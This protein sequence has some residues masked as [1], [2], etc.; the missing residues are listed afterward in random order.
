MKLMR[1]CDEL[2]IENYRNLGFWNMKYRDYMYYY[3][4]F[5]MYFKLIFRIW[6]VKL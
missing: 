4:N 6:N 3:W 2:Y 1:I 5:L